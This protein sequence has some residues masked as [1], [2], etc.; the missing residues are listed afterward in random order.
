MLIYVDIDNTIC[1]TID[2]DYD[3]ST[4]IQENIDKINKLFGEG[5]KIIYWTARGGNSGKNWKNLTL[6][7]LNKWG[8][9]FHQ[10]KMNKPSYDLFICDKTKRIEEI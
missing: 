6:R 3:N 9:L 2:G 8:C 4:P 10:L 5:H 7:Q 1:H